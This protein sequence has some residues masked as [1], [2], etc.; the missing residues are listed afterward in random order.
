MFFIEGTC[1]VMLVLAA[2]GA[3]GAGVIPR[4]TGCKRS[5]IPRI[6]ARDES[7]VAPRTLLF[8]LV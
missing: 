4:L 3:V 1:S 8:V 2:N 5:A 6:G 7:V